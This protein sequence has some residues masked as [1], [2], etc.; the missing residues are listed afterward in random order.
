MRGGCGFGKQHDERTLGFDGRWRAMYACGCP[1]VLHPCTPHSSPKN[2]YLAW[3]SQPPPGGRVPW[4]ARSGGRLGGSRLL[5]ERP[6]GGVWAVLDETRTCVARFDSSIDDLDPVV[7]QRRPRNWNHAP[8]ITHPARTTRHKHP[9]R[10]LRAA[11]RSPVSDSSP[12]GGVGVSAIAC[13]SIGPEIACLLGWIH[14][15]VRRAGGGPTPVRVA[16]WGDWLGLGVIKWLV[17]L[18]ESIHAWN[19]DKRYVGYRI[20]WTTALDSA[21]AG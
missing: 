20:S 9:N 2:T 7:H 11:L 5:I 8:R 4:A 10:S 6:W 16:V 12:A 3:C 21:S 18:I 14:R 1:I 15:S 17:G 13:S 19:P